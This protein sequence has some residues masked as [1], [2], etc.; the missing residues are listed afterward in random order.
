MAKTAHSPTDLSPVSAP[1]VD[2]QSADAQS[3]DTTVVRVRR[4]P[5]SAKSEQRIKDILRVARAVFS[6]HGFERATTTD[7]A[8]RLGVSEATVFTY[9]RGKRELCVRVLS[10]WYDEIIV[11]IESKLPALSG[12]YAKLHFVVHSH[13]RHLLVDGTGLCALILAEGRARNDELGETFSA[14]QRRYTAPVMA[15]LA[16]A[17][18]CGEIRDDVPLRLLRAMIYGPMEHV[19][20]GAIRRN[21]AV[22]IDVTADQIMRLLWQTVQPPALDTLALMRFHSEVSGALARVKAASVLPDDPVATQPA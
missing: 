14:L 16:E 4:A 17:R 13:L 21:E 9:F 19:L 18:E 12:T 2:V 11:D 22:D 1:L 3:A 15:V 20:W 6:E 7:I 5:A 8:Q 10:D